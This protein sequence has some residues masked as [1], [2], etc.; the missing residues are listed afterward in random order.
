VVKPTAIG[1][2]IIAVGLL[3]GCGGAPIGGPD[4]VDGPDFELRIRRDGAEV[5]ARVQKKYIDL[6]Q[7][8]TIR[9]PFVYWDERPHPALP[10]GQ[11]LVL[12]SVVIEPNGATWLGDLALRCDG[13]ILG[14]A[15]ALVDGQYV[16]ITPIDLDG[17]GAYPHAADL[18]QA[19][20][21]GAGTPVFAQTAEARY[22]GGA[23]TD[24]TAQSG[25]VTTWTFG[26]MGPA[27]SA[28]RY[29]ANGTTE[30][31]PNVGMA[32]GFLVPAG[33]TEI[34]IGGQFLGTG[35]TTTAGR[36]AY[37]DLRL[38][39]RSNQTEC[40][41]VGW[42][43]FAYLSGVRQAAEARQE[44]HQYSPPITGLCY[45]RDG[46]RMAFAQADY[47]ADAGLP[48]Q[49]RVSTGS[50]TTFDAVFT[51]AWPS[52]SADGERLAF[53]QT[54]GSG[55][56]AI[57]VTEAEAGAEPVAVYDDATGQERWPAWHPNGSRIAF[58]SDK[59]GT[60]RL[61]TM[62]PDGTGVAPVGDL[63]GTVADWSFDGRRL[64]YVRDGQ[65][66]VA[67]ADGTGERL[68]TEGSCPRWSPSSL[69]LLVLRE[70]DVLPGWWWDDWNRAE[71]L[72]LY[73]VAVDTGVAD[74][75]VGPV[76]EFGS[77]ESS[78]FGVRTT[79]SSAAWKPFLE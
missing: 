58:T 27:E 48:V 29:L 79:I 75:V 6:A 21:C 30:Q 73:C 65:V 53:E 62:A 34:G 2:P 37:A 39:C 36:P 64:A 68:V 8:L 74:Y 43:Q 60:Q 71:H 31:D 41:L 1:I 4:A 46:V 47:P 14:Q 19:H 40:G 56:M 66:Y 51:G 3:A 69:S 16:H 11:H 33:A 32:W 25:N 52:W 61:Y 38:S 59:D 67:N 12:V 23:A 57:W 42:V 26:S 24:Y 54:A 22:G 35:R 49:V 76:I 72:S 13:S 70:T 28:P 77:A 9:A 18:L 50:V 44:Y 17:P 45:S 10:T 7:R 78:S 5:S 55:T 15:W 20:D 63:C